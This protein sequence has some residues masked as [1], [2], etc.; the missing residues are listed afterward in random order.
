MKKNM[1][2]LTL[3]ELVIVLAIVA[4]I[5]AIV[6]PNLFGITDRARLRSDIQSTIILQNALDLYR[7]ETG[8]SAGINITQVLQSLYSGGFI[9]TAMTSTGD[10]GPQTQEAAWV[11]SNN[12]ILLVVPENISSNTGITNGLTPNERAVIQNLP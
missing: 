2:G 10:T 6:A 11:L 12:R 7:L 5:G 9:S 3:M 8:R 1:S 4:I